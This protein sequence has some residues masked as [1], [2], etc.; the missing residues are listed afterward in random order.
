MSTKTDRQFRAGRK[1]LPIKLP[2]RQS[3]GSVI[4]QVVDADVRTDKRSRTRR[5][6]KAAGR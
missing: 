3:D 6:K 1:I 5:E 2:V 4:V